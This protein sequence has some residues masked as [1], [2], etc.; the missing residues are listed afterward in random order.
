[1]DH[2]T[3]PAT[4]SSLRGFKANDH[5]LD[6]H[7]LGVE[8]YPQVGAKAL[9]RAACAPAALRKRIR[10]RLF[11]VLSELLPPLYIL[12]PDCRAS[13]LLMLCLLVLVMKYKI[14]LFPSN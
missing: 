3:A 14:Y 10:P 9:A 2:G 8:V 4:T 5:V 11:I 12:C 13:E 6:D 1:M 7:V